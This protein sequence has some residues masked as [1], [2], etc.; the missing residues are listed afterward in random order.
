LFDS[1]TLR[2]DGFEVDV[3]EDPSKDDTSR[4]VDRLKPRVRPDSVVM[5]FFGG[6]GIQVGQENYIIPVDAL[7]WAE[8]DVRRDGVGIE[9][10]LDLM[11]R[12]GDRA[13]I[14]VVEALRRN[15]SSSLD[16]IR[17]RQPCIAV[18]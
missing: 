1:K 13:K 10:V 11:K 14:V 3:M 7:I 15:P 12:R 9:L 18:G 8:T 16:P 5:R 17:T 4:A 6:Y 2:R